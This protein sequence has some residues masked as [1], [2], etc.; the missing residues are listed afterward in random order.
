MQRLRTTHLSLIAL[1]GIASCTGGDFCVAA[2][3]ILMSE[4]A[5]TALVQLDRETA[6]A[7]DAHNGTGRRL[8]GW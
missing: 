2:K 5:A 1:L 4:Q 8:C 6:E 7:I 3:E